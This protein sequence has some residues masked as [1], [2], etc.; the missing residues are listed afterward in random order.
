MT[1]RYHFLS[2]V[3]VIEAGLTRFRDGT[4]PDAQPDGGLIYKCLQVVGSP[5]EPM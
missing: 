1:L 5:G 3:H 4:Q 2:K